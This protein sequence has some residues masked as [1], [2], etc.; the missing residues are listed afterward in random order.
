MQPHGLGIQRVMLHKA[1]LDSSF[2]V[3]E[4]SVTHKSADKCGAFHE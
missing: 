2:L 4:P 3:G 1:I